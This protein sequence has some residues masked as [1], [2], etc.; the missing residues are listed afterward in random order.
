M[1]FQCQGCRERHRNC[2]NDCEKYK[3]VKCELE[4]L[5]KQ[6]RLESISDSTGKHSWN[7]QRSR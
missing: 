2:H 3:Q 5:K 6:K 4:A 1:K 7:Y